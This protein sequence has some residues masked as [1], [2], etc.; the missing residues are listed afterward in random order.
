MNYPP[1]PQPTPRLVYSIPQT[2][3]ELGICE[4]LVWKLIAQQK[5]KSI[6][7]GLRRTGVPASE[8]AR[9]AAEGTR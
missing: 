6:K 1:S 5:I 2:A 9:V 4:R 7:I 3:H 8:V